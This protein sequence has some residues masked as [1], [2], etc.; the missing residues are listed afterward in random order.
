[1]PEVGSLAHVV[2]TIQLAIA[3][4]FLLTGIASFLNVLSGRLA[5]VIDRSRSIEG[6]QAAATRGEKRRYI[7]ELR[8]LDQRISLASRAIFLC[9][10]SAIFVCA[11]VAMMFVARLANQ[12]LAVVVALMFV[13]SMVLLIAGLI[14][15]ILE[16]RIATQSIHVSEDLLK[17]MHLSSTE[18]GED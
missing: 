18:T 7:T 1:M 16:V 9:V 11:M 4:V 6:A 17:L 10:A 8:V 12:D 13:F 2:Q 5:R 15:F 14:F 3:P